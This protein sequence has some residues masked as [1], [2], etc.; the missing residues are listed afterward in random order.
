ME[1]ME[2]Y[3]GL[4]LSFWEM[5]KVSWWQIKLG[6]KTL[7]VDKVDCKAFESEFVAGF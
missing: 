6:K 2:L 4:F 3:Q 5:E 1:L 7:N